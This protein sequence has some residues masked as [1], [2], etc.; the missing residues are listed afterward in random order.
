[1]TRSLGLCRMLSWCFA[2][3]GG[4]GSLSYKERSCK[5]LVPTM[6]SISAP[7]TRDQQSA[8]ARPGLEAQWRV[9]SPDLLNDNRS[10]VVQTIRTLLQTSRQIYKHDL[11]D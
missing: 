9:T 6:H 3:L 4:P 8:S 7:I 5:P 11:P 2:R 10:N 1:M